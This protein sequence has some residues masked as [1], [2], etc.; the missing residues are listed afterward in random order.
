VESAWEETAFRRQMRL[1]DPS[2][3]RFPCW[4]GNLEMNGPLS[5]LLHY[6]RP[7]CH[8]LTVAD[9]PHPELDQIA[10]TEFAVY[11]QIEQGK[12]AT[13]PGE[14]QT[15]ANGPDILQ[16]ERGLLS[17]NLPFVPEYLGG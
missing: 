2:S 8:R 5:F 4:L 16:L 14:L 9:I 6:D 3:N 7:R 10:G 12:F 13:P 15:D 17:D 1:T 11:R